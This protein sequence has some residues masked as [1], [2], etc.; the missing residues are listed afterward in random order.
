MRTLGLKGAVINSHTNGEYLDDRKFWPILECAAAL[1]VP[2]YIHPR[3]PS[4]QMGG[5][6]GIPGFLVGWGYALVEAGFPR[7]G[8]A[9]AQQFLSA[10]NLTW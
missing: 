7:M 3:D 4:P 1:G 5:P 9:Q 8:L 6:L 2:I 10:N